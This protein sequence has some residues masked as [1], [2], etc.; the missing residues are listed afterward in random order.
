MKQNPFGGSSSG[1]GKEEATLRAVQAF[2]MAETWGETHKV[3]EREQSLLLTELADQLL[4]IL[5]IEAK[6][7]DDPQHRAFGAILEQHRTLLRRSRQIGIDQAWSEFLQTLEQENAPLEQM[8]LDW[9][10]TRTY[11]DQRRFLEEHSEL[12]DQRV[13][14]ILQGLIQQYADQPRE[15]QFLRDSLDFIRASRTQGIAAGW[16]AFEQARRRASERE[17]GAASPNPLSEPSA[18]NEEVMRA[19]VDAITRLLQEWNAVP[20]YRGERSYLERHPEMLEQAVDLVLDAM[21]QAA[22][23]HVDELISSGAGDRQQV[24]RQIR[25]LVNR[26]AMLRDA[27]ARGGSVAAIRDAYVNWNGGFML[28]IPSWLEEVEQRTAD[29]RRNT[30]PDATR[31]R[32]NLWRDSIARAR[33]E[34]GVPLE[35]IAEMQNRLA[36]ATKEDRSTDR[37]R[38]IEEAIHLRQDALS[39][40]T[41]E[42]FPHQWAMTQGNLGN[43]YQDRPTGGR[44]ENLERAIASYQAALQVYSRVSYPEEWATMQNN[45]GNA[46]QERLTGN[47]HDNLEQSLACYQNALQVRTREDA[48]EEW[49]LTMNNLGNTYNL[50]VA[51][52]R[53]E[54]QE[55]AL[56]CYQNALDINS[57]ET[58]PERRVTTLTNMGA[59]Y[60]DRLSGNRRDN[61]E[62]AISCWREVLEIATRD[63]MPVQWAVAQ[64]GLGSALMERPTGDRGANLE[65]ALGCFNA[66]LVLFTRDNAPERW[67]SVQGML[68]NL[69]RSRVEGSHRDNIEAAIGHYRAA[70]G[71]FNHDDT[72]DQW[73][74]SHHHLGRALAQREIGDRRVNLE[75]AIRSFQTALQVFT[76]DT[77]PQEYGTLQSNL[78]SVF[79][80]REAGERRE[81]IELAIACFQNALRVFSPGGGA[82]DWGMVMVNL[83]NT[84]LERVDG[85]KRANIEQ[86]V[87]CY[88]NA[89]QIFTLA[90]FPLEHRDIQLHLAWAYYWHLAGLAERQGDA[91]AARDTFALAHQAFAAA[92]GAQVEVSWLALSDR[93]SLMPSPAW[94]DVRQMYARDA[95]CLAQMTNARDAAVALEAGSALA[96]PASADA[97]LAGVCAVHAAAFQS[98]RADLRDA[99]QGGDHSALGAARA[100]F[101]AVRD[102]IRAHCQPSFLPGEPRYDDIARAAA[103]GQALLYLAATERGGLAVALAPATSA[104]IA[105]ELLVLPKLTRQAVAGWLRRV[106]DDGRV[107]GGFEPAVNERGA[108]VLRAWAEQAADRLSLRLDGARD[109]LAAPYAPLKSA[110]ARVI[111]LWRTEGRDAQ[112]AL[113]LSQA[114]ADADVV[115]SLSWFVLQAELEAVQHS[116]SESLALDVRQWLDRAGLENPDQ[117]IALVAG[118]DLSALP[119]HAAWAR[120]D[121]SAD[122]L[123]PLGDTCLIT[124]ARSALSLAATRSTA[125]ARTG[126]PAVTLLWPSGGTAMR[127]LLARYEAEWGAHPD[128]S[129]AW[130]L[131]DATRWLRGARSD[132][133][134][135]AVADLA[136]A[137]DA[138]TPSARHVAT[139]TPYAN[140]IY[141]AAAILTESDT[142]RLPGVGLSDQARI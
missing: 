12:L 108:D 142:P 11:S 102:Q 56:R 49:A 34:G 126:A 65:E 101:L 99:Q 73:A 35:T 9:L 71:V 85:D 30:T 1:G 7:S 133:I 93:D 33:L 128:R 51:G 114:L 5:I 69:Y 90:E 6:N 70:L 3:L 87:Q 19:S 118:G 100:A 141:W 80:V 2:V 94:D 74:A 67:A 122:A 55:Q 25:D 54:N 130:A 132:E 50:R 91:A 58:M 127:L 115:R 129:P 37:A 16:L 116:L 61:I 86:A 111:A 82:L 140:A 10:N 123:V 48:P 21:I 32:A 63:R 64:V 135:R 112:L 13:D 42:R 24:M 113:P 97:S 66:A 59:A 109:A 43:D 131:R 88:H 106:D 134:A 45:I 119:L 68:G 84:F 39:V 60:M 121:A 120:Q 139:P 77:A 137:G 28:D 89:L 75:E 95:W 22:R 26:Q 15:Q 46:Y 40:Y 47:R 92:R 96:G 17:G 20:T 104:R 124:Y 57:R 72:P 14:T 36:S 103:P 79:L 125:P 105:A 78:G 23:E 53:R 8:V 4:T 27:R 98:Q 110:V 44:R 29:L 41:L 107:I 38:A 138:T 136:G 83:G 18:N 52:D 81:N 117:A 31:Q 62:H 76:P